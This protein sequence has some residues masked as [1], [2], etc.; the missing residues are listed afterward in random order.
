MDE[1]VLLAKQNGRYKITVTDEGVHLSVWPPVYGGSEVAKSV[2]I[3]D[4]INQK[5]TGFDS[6]FISQVIREAMGIPVL[7]VNSLPSQDGRYQITATDAGVHLSVW[8]STKDGL[9][10]AKAAIIQ[11]LTTQNFTGF[12]S[13]FIS[14]VIRDAVGKPVLIINSLPSQDGRYQITTTD[15]G[16]HLS[17]WPP[18]KDGSPA[19]KASII[20]DL[21]DLNFVNFD[22]DFISQVIKEAIGAPVLIV[23]SL[24]TDE[25]VPHIRVKVG[26]D[27]LEARID[28][29]IPEDGPMLTVEQLLDKLKSAGVVYGIDEDILETLTQTRSGTNIICAHGT[30]PCNGKNA[31]LK[32][33]IDPDSQ[34]RPVELED[35]RIDFK[36]INSFLCVEEG[37]LLV[38][39]VPATLGTPGIDVFGLSIPAKPGKD[40]NMPKGKN[41]ILVDDWRLYAAIHGHLHIFLDKRINVIPVIVID[42]DVD[43]STGNIDFKG[44]VIVRGTVKP[45]FSIKAGG[46][47]EVYGTVCGGMVEANSI[48]IHKGIQGMNRSIIK[49]RERLVANFIENATVYVEQDI[50]VSDAVLNSSVFS[51]SR[52]IV[53]GRRGLVR[54]GRIS[55]GE[56]IRACTIGNQ[57]GTTTE[58]EV[59]I[60][61]FLKDELLNLSQEIKKAQMLYEELKLQLSFI[62]NQGTNHLSAEKKELY[63]KNEAEYNALPDR[64]EELQQRKTNIENLVCS[65]KPGRIRVSHTIYPGVKMF[66]GSLKKIINDQ[67]QYVSFYVQGSDIK[68]SSL[69]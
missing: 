57:S 34:G 19:A 5:F 48:I 66:I 14:Q 58:L 20:Q 42:T 51:G 28:V 37:Q 7:I 3:Q 30:P 21:T 32:Y 25:R 65:L 26:L 36:E 33:H 4:L 24:P 67:Y 13:D 53:E 41:V 64:L 60:N 47:V 40:K 59:A 44:S 27:R 16:V 8:P 31:Y 12:D 2:I 29:N 68:F 63:K 49:A 54:G 43:Y 35:G 15:E 1:T 45:D 17:V 9:P 6:D 52:V 10:A 50:I 18:V 38:E 62:R 61:P 23:N 46:N 22:S 55:A 56:V 11:E 39:K 69:R